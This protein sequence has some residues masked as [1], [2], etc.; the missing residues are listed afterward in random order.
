MLPDKKHKANIGGWTWPSLVAASDKPGPKMKTIIGISLGIL[1]LLLVIGGFATWI[2]NRNAQTFAITSKPKFEYGTRGLEVVY[3]LVVSD[4]NRTCRIPWPGTMHEPV[5]LDKRRA[6]TFTV[7]QPPSWSATVPVVRRVQLEGQTI[8][9]SELCGVH[10][11]K[12]AC[13]EVPIHYGFLCFDEGEPSFE[14]ERHLFPHRR[15][16]SLG[17][18]V[19]TP[20]SPVTRT[21]HVCSEC[22]KAYEAWK[23]QHTNTK[24]EP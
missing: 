11:T 22:K 14:V 15:E 3:E 10:K 13:Q 1:L 4:S 17:G 12:I 2:G 16:F 18:C 9:D 21:V 6:Y 24:E 5:R 23:D 7:T 20:D 8:Y 19:T